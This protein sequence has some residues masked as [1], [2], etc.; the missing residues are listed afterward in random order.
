M[1]R[2][3]AEKET[4]V[5]TMKTSG[6]I[7]T[8][9]RILSGL[10]L[11]LT[12]AAPAGAVDTLAVKVVEKGPWTIYSFG[13][14]FADNNPS[15][16]HPYRNASRIPCVA[17]DGSIWWGFY[18][19]VEKGAIRFDGKVWT[20]YTARDGLMDG[21][22]LSIVQAEDGTLYF[23][24]SHKGKAAV[25]RYDGKMWR[26]YT[27]ADGLVG[28]HIGEASAVDTRG[29]LWLTTELTDPV[30]AAF[31]D[32]TKGGYGVFRF[33][34]KNWRNFRVEDGL[35]H[36]RVY[37]LSVGHEGSIWIATFE[38]VSR[39]DGKT[40][41]TYTEKDG[42]SIPKSYRF[43]VAQDGNV[44]CIHG[45]A[46]SRVSIFNGTTWKRIHEADG[47]PERV[48]AVYQT[49]DGAIWFGTPVNYLKAY[50]TK[51]LLR[52]QDGAW[53]RILKE[54]GLPGDNVHSIA[55]ARDGSLYL[56]VPDVGIV[57]YRPDF[58]ALGTISG[59]VKK[60]D[61][62][63]W[64]GVGISVV[65]TAGQ[66]RAGAATDAEGRYRVRAFPETYRVSVIRGQ[67]AEP[68]E[69]EVAAG[70][71]RQKVDF[72][73]TG[74]R[75]GIVVPAG[76]G[77]TAKAGPGRT[78]K[79][80][81]GFWQ[82]VWQTLSSS[83]GLVSA[84][85]SD[86]LQ[87]KDGNL[88]FAGVFG[89]G[90][91]RYDGKSFTNFTT[92]DGLASNEVWCILADRE[93]NLWFGT[94]GGVSRYDGKSFTN[95]TTQD[96]LVHHSVQ[97]ILQD[98]EGSFWFGTGK[99]QSEGGGVSRYDGKSFI[100]F[101]TQDGLAGNWVRS[102]LQDRKGNLWFATDGGV[103]RYDPMAISW[104]SGKS[105]T[106][107]TTQDGLAGNGVSSIL[108]DQI[109]HLWFGTNGGAS[110]YDGKTFLNFTTK[111]GMARSFVWSICQDRQ[112]N[113]WFGTWGG[114][115]SRYDG[116]TFTNF[117]TKDGLAHF[118]VWRV[119]ADREGNI[120][121]GTDGGGVSRYQGESF[122]T[123]TQKD[124]LASDWLITVL[125]DNK[126]NIWIGSQESG[127]GRYDGKTWTGVT[128]RARWVFRL[129][130]AMAIQRYRSP[131]REDIIALSG[132][133]CDP[134]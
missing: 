92:E 44:W 13:T 108:E 32:R 129:P 94:S 104:Q 24:G 37:G 85:I 29:N 64:V 87:D 133:G 30:Q 7:S 53:L 67:G 70:K 55:Q 88:W 100:N 31:E 56:T 89:G 82:G 96:G 39:F 62:T 130:K 134:G 47:M 128:G 18:G 116:K 49:Q 117:T 101:T 90:V 78:V 79:A 50:G 73:P 41:T 27:E 118:E 95:F 121:F 15:S 25:T 71:E 6:T 2:P 99:Y 51:G 22:V 14:P 5:P 11:A 91:S 98:R 127:V 46:D 111:E 38:G 77:K 122:T 17:Q 114:G 93:R 131:Q 123:F 34:G 26:I 76:P 69:V 125:A 33:D 23:A 8:R 52:Y 43:L 113:Y 102:I 40:W 115:V 61:G 58:T 120:W 103:S 72:T 74:V 119:M 84:H 10:L 59:T 132:V 1:P 45:D 12:L 42:L 19:G 110:R 54:D 63:P 3:C 75:Q 107:F 105:F 80:G 48:L 126:G 36:N 106:N 28:N 66:A 60:P 4:G 65:D 81:L 9:R 86:I 35:A 112:G 124:G 83:D 16:T 97:S 57:R 20:K 21:I 68:V 109:G